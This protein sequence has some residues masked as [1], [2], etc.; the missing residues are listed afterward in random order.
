MTPVRS[1]PSHRPNSTY[2]NEDAAAPGCRIV[3]T[4]DLTWIEVRMGESEVKTE[5]RSIW[6]PALATMLLTRADL[7]G[8]RAFGD[9][10]PLENV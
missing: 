5:L 9:R 3:H 6:L 4:E 10:V 7:F 1:K 8:Q 2:P